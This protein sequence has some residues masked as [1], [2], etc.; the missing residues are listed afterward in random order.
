MAP[1]VVPHPRRTSEMSKHQWRDFFSDDIV[2][3]QEELH[4]FLSAYHDNNTFIEPYNYDSL[5]E[6]L[7]NLLYQCSSNTRKC[8]RLL[9]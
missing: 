3:I 8:Y 9:R 7:T 6:T 4:D 1:T 2:R 5:N